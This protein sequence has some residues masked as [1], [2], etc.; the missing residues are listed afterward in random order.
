MTPAIADASLVDGPARTVVLVIGG[1][2]VLGWL[3]AWL[4][5]RAAAVADR[6]EPGCDE[7][8]WL[9]YC[10]R[11]DG[12]HV[13]TRCSTE[14]SCLICDEPQLYASTDV[15]DHLLVEALHADLAAFERGER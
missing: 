4:L 2:T 1:V 14:W 9:D 13:F 10:R 12:R 11:C 8:A 6:V 5:C 3:A 7:L 15:Y